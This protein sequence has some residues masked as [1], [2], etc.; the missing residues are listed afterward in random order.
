M[1]NKVILIG[2]IGNTPELKQVSDL[3]SVLNFSVATSESYKKDGEWI[4]ETEW[5]SIVLFNPSE[6]ITDNLEKGKKVYIEGKLQTDKYTDQDGVQ[7][8]N[9]KIIARTLKILK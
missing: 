5:H 6:Y 8:Y 4:D 9:T 7:R 2:N 1:I 3:F